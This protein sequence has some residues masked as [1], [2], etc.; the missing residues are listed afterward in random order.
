MGPTE[1]VGGVALLRVEGMMDRMGISG[2]V[3]L[4]GNLS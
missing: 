3:S 2:V 4:L 1:E